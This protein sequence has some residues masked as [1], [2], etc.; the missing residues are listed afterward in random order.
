MLCLIEYLAKE[1][2]IALKRKGNMGL[3]KD[4][5]EYENYAGDDWWER[6]EQDFDGCSDDDEDAD[7]EASGS[8]GDE[9]DDED[10][11]R[12]AEQ[13]KKKEKGR[14]RTYR[15]GGDGYKGMVRC[16]LDR[17]R[18]CGKNREWNVFYIRRERVRHP[19]SSASAAAPSGYEDVAKQKARKA[20]EKSQN[21]TDD[22]EDEDDQG[23]GRAK[24]GK[25][26]VGRYDVGVFRSV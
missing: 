15:Q 23:E 19:G 22:D 7:P 10:Y 21:E 5:R 3:E 18:N 24:K 11:N 17:R 12:K 25:S 1:P 16:F 9:D 26:G 2:A 8:K 14:A 13:L 20:A 6:G 4:A